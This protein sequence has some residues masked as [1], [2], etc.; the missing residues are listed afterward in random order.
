MKAVFFHD[1]KIT[2]NGEQLFSTGGLNNRVIRRFKSI[3]NEFSLATRIDYERS[4][5]NL[6]FIS[7]KQ[8]IN[9][10][11]LPNLSTIDRKNYQA[12]SKLIKALVLHNDIIISRLPSFIGFLGIHYARKFNKKY[13]IEVAGC[14]FDSF[15]YYGN[16]KGY[17]I[18]VPMY[19]L[20]RF[21]LRQAPNVLYVTSKFLQ[22]R[23]P[24]KG[25]NQISCSNVELKIDET[26]LIRRKKRI[27]KHKTKI[28]LGIIGALQS[29]Y[30]GYDIA[31]KALNI[32]I[33]YKELKFHLEIVGGGSGRE[34][35]KIISMY[36]LDKN[37]T[38]LGP[39]PHPDGVFNWLDSIDI[40]IHPSRVEGLPRSLI[41]A[42]SRAC[43]CI[44]SDAGGIPELL[45]K[46]F[47]HKK[48]DYKGLSKLIVSLLD[49]E[50]QWIH[51]QHCFNISKS[52]DMEIL[53]QKRGSFYRNCIKQKA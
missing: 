30:K 17:L 35:R 21:Y 40:Y 18:A 5:E 24:S 28:T 19:L 37:I 48:K 3:F 41:E 6:T 43:P 11:P 4:T 8:E 7:N 42:M 36:G 13:A 38:L 15:R 45:P 33:R 51:A 2:Y 32:L 52:Y 53:N 23:Y 22:S 50:N 34:I 31:L 27:F 14:P 20:T 47:Q 10:I 49:P 12:A 26:V 46:Q 29:K 44:G 1:H 16:M 9:H 39:L 25:I